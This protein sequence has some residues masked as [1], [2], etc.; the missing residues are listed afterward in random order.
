M[1]E[2]GLDGREVIDGY[3][4]P[5]GAQIEE[6]KAKDGTVFYRSGRYACDSLHEVVVRIAT[7]YLC[8]RCGKLTGDGC[9][10][11]CDECEEKE[12]HEE[13]LKYPEV[14]YDG[15]PLFVNDRFVCEKDI[16]SYFRS[17]KINPENAEIYFAVKVLPDVFHMDEWLDDSDEWLDDSFE[18]LAS[19]DFD[20]SHDE[21]INKYIRQ[22][23]D[24]YYEEDRSKRV[25]FPEGF[26]DNEGGKS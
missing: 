13:Y 1:N 3:V 25:V 9:Q 16:K 4:L 21:E 15:G 22:A 23:A 19:V 6:M 2:H 10:H 17:N 18:D 26:F 12:A 7:D 20:T 8:E 14:Q 11:I 24:N 5:K